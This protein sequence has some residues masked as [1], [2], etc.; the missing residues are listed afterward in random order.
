MRDSPL[1]CRVFSRGQPG[2]D[3]RVGAVLHAPAHHAVRP[4][5]QRT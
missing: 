2:V 4:R 1:T 5:T 3:A